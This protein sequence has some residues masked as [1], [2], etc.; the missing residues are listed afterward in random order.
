MAKEFEIAHDLGQEE[1][2]RRIAAGIPKLR[3]KIPGNPEVAAEWQ[4]GGR[5]ALRIT[6]MGQTIRVDGEVGEDAVRGETRVPV[7]LSVM[8]GQIADVVRES[9][10]RMLAKPA[11]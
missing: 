1:A 2:R 7:M 5:L 8:A 3:E 6:A 11:A 4:D 10:T 9:I